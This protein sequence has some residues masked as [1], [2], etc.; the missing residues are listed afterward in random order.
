DSSKRQEYFDRAAALAEYAGDN[1]TSSIRVIQGL[2][3]L[4]AGDF[5]GALIAFLEA[6]RL[7]EK[8]G[9]NAGL[10]EIEALMF[11]LHF[12]KEDRQQAYEAAMSGADRAARIQDVTE[13][14]SIFKM[15]LQLYVNVPDEDLSLAYTRSAAPTMAEALKLQ[16]GAN[17]LGAVAEVFYVSGT[18]RVMSDPTKAKEAEVLLSKAVDYALQVVR[19]D[20]ATMS[21]L[22]LAMLNRRNPTAFANHIGLAREFARLSGDPTLLQT[23]IRIQEGNVGPSPRR[24][25]L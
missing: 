21:Q 1:P 5:D 3:L 20:I 16:F 4:N 15:A 8:S 11:R 12:A 14:A 9:S 13:Q 7:V 10:L 2:E 23:V 25:T 22:T 17:D 18:F 6:R 19:F 24:N